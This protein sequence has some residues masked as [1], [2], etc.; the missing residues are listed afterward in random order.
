MQLVVLIS[1]STELIFG[2][3][4]LMILANEL[5]Y[6]QIDS[7]WQ[8]QNTYDASDLQPCWIWEF[9]GAESHFGHNNLITS[10]F[11]MCSSFSKTHLKF[12][13]NEPKKTI[14]W[15]FIRRGRWMHRN[16]V[17]E[18]LSA[19]GHIVRCVHTENERFQSE[20]HGCH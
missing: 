10:L 20:M 16:M 15:N 3:I 5:R 6:A 18:F 7:K 19:C 8:N 4:V 12:A 2:F 17:K 11:L 1:Q 14:R 13:K 9:F